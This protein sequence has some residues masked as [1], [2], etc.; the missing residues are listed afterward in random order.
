MVLGL[1]LD[2]QHRGFCD[3]SPWPATQSMQLQMVVDAFPPGPSE[4]CGAPLQAWCLH[5][6]RRAGTTYCICHCCA[7]R[8]SRLWTLLSSMPALQAMLSCSSFYC[9]LQ[10]DR[11]LGLNMYD[12][13]MSQLSLPLKISCLLKLSFWLSSSVILLLDHCYALGN[14]A[15]SCQWPSTYSNRGKCVLMCSNCKCR[16]SDWL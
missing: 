3:M 12:I 6:S 14:N 5:W 11:M 16:W 9:K 1:E 8:M 2:L 13:I 10:T 15:S 7:D 4:D